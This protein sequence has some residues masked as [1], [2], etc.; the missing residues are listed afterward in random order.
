MPRNTLLF[1]FHNTAQGKFTGITIINCEM[2]IIGFNVLHKKQMEPHNYP[3]KNKCENQTI[4]IDIYNI[5][6]YT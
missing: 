5:L 1:I 2:E 4:I 3:S 6:E